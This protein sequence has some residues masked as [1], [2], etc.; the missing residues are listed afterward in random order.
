M[1]VAGIVTVG[2]LMAAK[3]IE[4]NEILLSFHDFAKP[5][6]GTNDQEFCELTKAL[7][8]VLYF[9]MSLHRGE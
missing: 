5:N 4:T 9:G 2:H 8:Q 1:T 3:E 6:E 7:P